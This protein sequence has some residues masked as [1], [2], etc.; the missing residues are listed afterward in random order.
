[1]KLTIT[2]AEVKNALSYTST[3]PYAFMVWCL[4]K[5]RDDF[6]FNFVFRE[7]GWEGVDWMFLAQ[8]RDK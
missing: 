2:S 8:D 4:V 3:P 1:V 5:H 7:I 6:T